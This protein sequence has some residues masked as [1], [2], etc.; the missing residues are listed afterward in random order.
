[1][2]NGIELFKG[3]TVRTDKDGNVSLNDLWVIAGSQ[4]N[5]DPRQWK[6][7]EGA[8]FIKFS[9]EFLNVPEKHIIKSQRGAGGGTYAHKQIA[10]AYAKY[11][12][13]E[14]HHTVNQVFFERIEEEKNPQL[15]VDRAVNSWK[16]KGKTDEW[17]AKRLKS[18]S[19]RKLLTGTLKA[20]GCDQNGYRLATN[21]MYAPQYGGD[22]GLVRKKLGI[23]EG[24]NT[25]EAMNEIQLATIELTEMIAAKNIKEKGL[26]GNNA[27]VQECNTTSRLIANS[28]S[29]ALRTR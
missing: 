21:A 29:Q 28:V 7:K 1:M 17:I 14:L 10:L 15:A 6:R 5:K 2:Q 20:A 23:S 11:L 9:S 27:C 25:R 24:A 19:T 16:K 8:E 26:Y 13:H 3:A 12:S 18:V 4:Q 22:A